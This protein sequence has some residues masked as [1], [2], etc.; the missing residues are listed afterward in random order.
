MSLSHGILGFLNYGKMSGYDLAKV[1][2]ESVQFFGTRK[3]AIFTLRWISLK[4]RGLQHTNV[5]FKTVNQTKSFIL[6]PMQA[7]RNLSVGL[8]MEAKIPQTTLK[9]RF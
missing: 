1:F 3:T 5:L 8:P 9:V 4:K 7:G 6:L 2:N